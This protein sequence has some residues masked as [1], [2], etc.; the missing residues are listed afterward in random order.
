MATVQ[1]GIYNLRLDDFEAARDW[2]RY[3]HIMHRDGVKPLVRSADGG[4]YTCVGEAKVRGAIEGP[5][6]TYIRWTPDVDQELH[7]HIQPIY[8]QIVT[9][10]RRRTEHYEEIQAIELVEF[11]MRAGR[12]HSDESPADLVRSFSHMF[13]Q[14]GGLELGSDVLTSSNS[15]SGNAGSD[16]SMT[17]ASGVS[18]AELELG[19]RIYDFVKSHAGFN[20][21]LRQAAA[22]I[23]HFEYLDF[24]RVHSD[25]QKFINECLNCGQYKHPY[26]D[27]YCGAMCALFADW[28]RRGEQLTPP[29]LMN[30]C[31]DPSP[32]ECPFCMYTV[33]WVI[34]KRDTD[35]ARL[36]MIKELAETTVDVMVSMD[37]SDEQFLHYLTEGSRYMIEG[38]E[39]LVKTAAMQYMS[40]GAFRNRHNLADQFSAHEV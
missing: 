27:G 18:N 31:F 8:E 7:D 28:G 38:T 24:R 30:E 37:L 26:C 3:D 33:L 17:G 9:R 34:D 29:R 36:M 40:G 13:E 4:K 2:I 16:L 21:G 19:L 10:N 39:E 12:D 11:E 23:M 32:T 15:S 20:K 1:R 14:A 35:A 5:I 25:I 6:A 22:R